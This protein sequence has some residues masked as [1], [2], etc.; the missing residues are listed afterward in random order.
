MMERSDYR[1]LGNNNSM[2]FYDTRGPS[3][4]FFFKCNFIFFKT[5]WVNLVT[6]SVCAIMSSRRGL[7]WWPSV[8]GENK[9]YSSGHEETRLAA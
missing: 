2:L 7:R 5:C 1:K 4:F 8:P 6:V 3:E 9:T